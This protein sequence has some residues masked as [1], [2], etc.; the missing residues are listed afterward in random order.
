MQAWVYD[1]KTKQGKI[2][3]WEDI[4]FPVRTDTPEKAKE[5][6]AAATDKQK[7]IA[8]YLGLE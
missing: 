3:E 7:F 5:D 1:A 2:E 6:Y 4:V 8:K